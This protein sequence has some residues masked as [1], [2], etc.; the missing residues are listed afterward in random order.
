MG[1]AGR[2]PSALLAIATNHGSSTY[3]ALEAQYRR[4]MTRGLQAQVAYA[5]SHSMDNS[6]TDAG[7]Y[8][9]GSGLNPAQD[10]ASSD[11]DVRHTLT[12]GFTYEIPRGPRARWWHGWAVDGMVRAR[13]GFPINVLEAEQDQGIALENAF[14]PGLLGGQPLWIPGA[15]APGGRRIHRGAFQAAPNEVQGSLG[16]NALSGFGMSQLDPAVR[17]EFVI[18]ER[19]TLESRAVAC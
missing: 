17:R 10:R 8:W 19:R 5:W 12:A 11:F 16:R 6:S 3:Q 15:S 18:A 13:S 9:A 4:R 2:V 7:L 1:G 14:R